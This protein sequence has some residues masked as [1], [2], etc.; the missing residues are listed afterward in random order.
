ML[1]NGTALAGRRQSN[2][3][4]L[5]FGKQPR[6]AGHGPA[7]RAVLAFDPQP[8][9]GGGKRRSGGNVSVGRTHS[10]THSLTHLFTHSL[11]HLLTHSLTH[12]VRRHKDPRK[13]GIHF[14]HRFWSIHNPIGPNAGHSG[15]ALRKAT[16]QGDPAARCRSPRRKEIQE[17]QGSLC[18]PPGQ[19]WASSGARTSSAKTSRTGAVPTLPAWP[20]GREKGK[21]GRLGQPGRLQS[22]TFA[23]SPERI[24]AVCSVEER[25]G[26]LNLYYQRTTIH[27]SLGTAVPVTRL[28]Y[29]RTKIHQ[30]AE[31]QKNPSTR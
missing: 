17:V 1:R 10:L 22:G 4:C 30:I 16:I 12:T 14:L 11:T 28:Y 9:R 27:Q 7:A 24:A 20:N 31:N 19:S 6:A 23:P 8:V 2:K 26:V 15:K 5:G 21:R 18:G 29:Q 25:E 13:K 3:W